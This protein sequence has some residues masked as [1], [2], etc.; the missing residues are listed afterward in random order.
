MTAFSSYTESAIVEHFLRGNAAAVPANQF[1]ALY[2]ADPTDDNSP[3]E[4]T[5][6]G[7]VRVSSDWSSA[8]ALGETSNTNQ[9]IYPANG[10]PT[11]SVTV[12]HVAIFDSLVGGNM[13]I[14]GP[15]LV[16]KTVDPTDVFAAAPG[17]LIL[18]VD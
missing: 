18:T 16:P 12:T 8:N 6:I 7:Y 1:L 15:I 9:I 3:N 5:F 14:H 13:L 2:T 4:C 17:Q 11:A 10:N